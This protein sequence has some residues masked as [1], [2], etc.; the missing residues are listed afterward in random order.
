MKILV[1]GANGYIGRRLSDAL[2]KDEH[3]VYGLVRDLAKARSVREESWTNFEALQCDLSLK[4][5]LDQFDQQVDVAYFLVHGMS[6]GS[7]QDLQER[8]EETARHFIE[9]C[10]HMGCR[11]I[12]YLSGI[13]PEGPLSDHLESRHS[14][15]KVLLG[16]SI[17]TTVLRSAIVV[18]AGSASFEI[19]RDLVEKL[20]VMIAPKWLNSKCQPIAV[21]DCIGYM[22]DVIGREECYHQSYDI[23]GPDVFT[24]KQLLQIFAAKRNL[25][26]FVFTVPLLTPK[27]S[28]LWLTLVTAVPY[29]LARSLVQ[30]LVHDMVARNDD[31]QKVS[32]RRCLNYEEALDRAFSRVQS[33][34]VFSKWSDGLIDSP[35]DLDDIYVPHKGCFKDVRI[36]E[37]NSSEKALEKLWSIGGE[38]GWYHGNFLWE[39]RGYLDK[40]V[41]GAG[42]RRGR[43]NQKELEPGDVI[44]FWRVL[45]SSKSQKRLLLFAEMKLPGEAWLEFKLVNE[46]GVSKLVQIATFRPRGVLGRLYWYAVAP[47]HMFVF[48]GMAKKICL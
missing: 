5:D 28:S 34:N 23:A 26:R 25:K 9:L 48:P 19:M 42:L 21:R 40:M 12:I 39:I 22:V 45:I 47:L 2:L 41:G 29:S 46:K 17:P 30:S 27:L 20:P 10:E 6:H 32:S 14:V 8:E 37:T 35:K 33:D 4:P 36:T 24:Y 44:D 16:S 31:I 15:E 18:G 13:T 38:N 3:H 1:S 11:Q 7:S 43:R